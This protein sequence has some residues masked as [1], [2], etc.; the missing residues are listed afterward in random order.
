VIG[1]FLP[2]KSTNALSPATWCCRMLGDSRR[3]N[4]RNS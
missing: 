3:S 4:S 1:I 2:E